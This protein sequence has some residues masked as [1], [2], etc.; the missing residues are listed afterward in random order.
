MNK[1]HLNSNRTSNIS[2]NKMHLKMSVAKWHPFC[3]CLNGFENLDRS[4][5]YIKCAIITSGI[6]AI[7][8]MPDINVAFNIRYICTSR[9]RCAVCYTAHVA[10]MVMTM[11]TMMLV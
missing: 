6:P 10:L 1:L 9:I 8:R 4:N 2:V 7:Y 11:V 5:P 3:L